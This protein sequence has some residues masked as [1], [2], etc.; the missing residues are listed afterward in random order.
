MP[1]RCGQPTT[2]STTTAAPGSCG[3]AAASTGTS[4]TTSSSRA[5]STATTPSASG[6]T[7]RSTR[8]TTARR[9]APAC[10]VT[11]IAS[12]FRSITSQ[13]LIGNIT[14]LVWNANVAGM[15]NRAVVTFAASRLQFNVVQ[16]DVFTSDTVELV[17]PDRGLY[18]FQQTKPFLDARRQ[19]LAVFEDR[20]KL[21][22]TVRLDRRRKNRADQARSHRVR[23]QWRAPQRRRLSVLQDFQAGHGPRRLYL[24]GASRTDILQPERHRRRSRRSPTSSSFVRP[25]HCC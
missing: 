22:S 24:G 10:R 21:T 7:A 16:D 19:H 5:R 23:R 3:C 1:G 4:T 20:L 12:G 8:S 11:S 18:G 9:R 15:E 25:S 14:D 17:N 13:R 2:C 6:S